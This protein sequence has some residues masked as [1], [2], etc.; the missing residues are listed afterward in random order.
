LQALKGDGVSQVVESGHP[1]YKKGDLVYARTRWEEYSLI[2][3]SEICLK[4]EHTDLPLSYYI[5]VLGRYILNNFNLWF[6][7]I[8]GSL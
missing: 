7:L 6:I 5:G 8:F 2:P 4:I 3:S 1:D